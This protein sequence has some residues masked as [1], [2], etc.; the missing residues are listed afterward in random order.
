MRGAPPGPAALH[1]RRREGYILHGKFKGQLGWL[2][3]L[4]SKV[5][6]TGKRGGGVPPNFANVSNLSKVL[7][8]PPPP[9][10]SARFLG[11]TAIRAWICDSSKTSKDCVY[12]APPPPP[13]KNERAY[14]YGCYQCSISFK[15]SITHFQA[16]QIS[17]KFFLQVV[18]DRR[19]LGV[20]VL[21]LKTCEFKN[22]K[23]NCNPDFHLFFS[24]W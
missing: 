16:V 3:Q 24:V 13:K 9:P 23:Q 14:A 7:A 8:I 19:I 22:K 15:G 21:E 17:M 10:C 6:E 18:F 11:L 2:Q 12:P 4:L 5:Y 20:F 1:L